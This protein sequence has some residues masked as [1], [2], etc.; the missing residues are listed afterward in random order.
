MNSL[1]PCPFCGGEAVMRGLGYAGPEN[2]Y[3]VY[4]NCSDCDA[5]GGLVVV[6]L[7]EGED[8]SD[9]IE[10]AADVWN[11]RNARNKKCL[12]LKK[13]GRLLRDFLALQ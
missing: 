4:V 1:K 3:D 6:D 10:Q 7:S 8:E 9:A 2:C 11:V 5:T 13:V 12:M